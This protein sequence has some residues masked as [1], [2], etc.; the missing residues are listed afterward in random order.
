MNIITTLIRQ[1]MATLCGIVLPRVLIGAFGSVVY[2]ATTSIAQFLSY[3][4]LLE[5]GIGR[6]ARGALYK[7]LAQGDIRQVSR[8]HTAVRR[9]FIKVA[10]IFLIYTLI[11]A[12]FYYDIAEITV[13]DRHYTFGLVLAIS[14]STLVN[15]MGGAADLTLLNADQK[16][17]LTNVVLTVTNVVNV[18][19][20]LVLVWLGADILVVKLAGGIIFLSRRIYYNIYIRKH[21]QLPKI[22]RDDFELKDKWTGMG[23]HMAFFLHANIDV[24]LL[25][26]I[27][28]LELVAVYAVYHLV[29]KSIWDI[30][31]S[32][33][34]GMEAA[35]GD[36][37][38]K[39]QERS[40]KQAYGKY[41]VTLSVVTLLFFGCTG[42]LIIPFIRLYMAGVT[43]ANYIQPLFALLLLLAEGMNCLVLPCTSLAIAAGKLKQTRWGSYGEAAINIIVSLILIW[44]DPLVGVAMGTLAATV[45]KCVYYMVYSA[46]NILHYG[47]ARTLGS[48]FITVAALVA[49]SGGGMLLLWNVQITDFLEWI[50]WGVIVFAVV[51]VIAV[52]VGF[53]VYPKEWKTLLKSLLKKK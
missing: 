39:N 8:V 7:P 9:F 26:L 12:F 37:I 4:S 41:K 10:G 13:F 51:C 49:L 52:A 48:F 27:T 35:F 17:Y 15:Y 45:F 30:A 22:E 14:L 11:L 21:Y 46:K 38:A 5:G 6:V 18:L 47:V 3:I 34:G 25:T 42:T 33:S 19:C 32:F 28:E 24:V 44:W 53:A 43:D 36:M 31:S 16:Q 1:L 23:Q 20:V 2:G 40:L 29:I 50:F